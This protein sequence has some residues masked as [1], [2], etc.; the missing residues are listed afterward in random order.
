MTQEQR[1]YLGEF[2]APDSDEANYSKEEMAIEYIGRYGYIDGD[3]HK[4][5]VLDQ[6]A[7]ILMGTPVLVTEARWSDGNSEIRLRTGEPSAEYFEWRG[8]NFDEDDE[9]IAP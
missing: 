4:Q 3:H 6:V 2:P 1:K 7:R 5:W 8:E 9:G